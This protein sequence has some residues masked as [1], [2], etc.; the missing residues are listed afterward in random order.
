MIPFV[1][2]NILLIAETCTNEEYNEL[3][4]PK[5]KPVLKIQDPI[6]VCIKIKRYA[7]C[8]MKMWAFMKAINDR[9]FV[10]FLLFSQFC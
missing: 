1:L 9:I 2:P 8:L 10:H 3:I 5:L 6:Q 4:F 7:N